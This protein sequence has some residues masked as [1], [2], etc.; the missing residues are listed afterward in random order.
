MKPQ[1]ETPRLVNHALHTLAE[2]VN[3]DTNATII[4]IDLFT[5]L[6]TNQALNYLSIESVSHNISDMMNVCADMST[7]LRVYFLLK[8]AI[9]ISRIKV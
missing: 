1:L 5:N 9:L 2:I 3:S 7:I 6:N 8:Y 4:D